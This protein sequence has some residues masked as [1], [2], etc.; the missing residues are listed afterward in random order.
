M[1]KVATGNTGVYADE[2]LKPGCQC[3]EVSYPRHVMRG[4]LIRVQGSVLY[5]GG[6]FL[7]T[8]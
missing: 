2:G 8:S 4:R 7:G 6:A 3:F 5:T 1:S